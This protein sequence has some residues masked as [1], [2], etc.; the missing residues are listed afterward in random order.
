[1]ANTPEDVIL[2]WEK[3][4]LARDVDGVLDLYE[5]DAVYVVASMD[6]AVRGKDAIRSVFE[7]LLDMGEVLS[8]STSERPCTTD[9]DLAYAHLTGSLHVRWKA[10]G[11]EEDLPIRATEVMH[12]GR[13]GRWRYVIDHA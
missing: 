9:G 11:E 7:G 3:A 4:F 5:D 10:S 1:M 6:I 8:M 12:R 13:D 2:E